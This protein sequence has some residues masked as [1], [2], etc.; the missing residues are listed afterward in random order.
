LIFKS[1]KKLPYLIRQKGGVEMVKKEKIINNKKTKSE[2][3]VTDGK[4]YS[5]IKITPNSIELR[6]EKIKS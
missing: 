4:N 6:V 1:N 5:S 2:T 3:V